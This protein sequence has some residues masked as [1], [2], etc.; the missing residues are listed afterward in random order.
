M[1]CRHLGVLNN[2]TVCSLSTWQRVLLISS[3]CILS[4]HFTRHTMS[5]SFFQLLPK[6]S[7]SHSSFWGEKKIVYSMTNSEFNSCD[8]TV[9]F[10]YQSQ[11]NEYTLCKHKVTRLTKSCRPGIRRWGGA[12]CFRVLQQAIQKLCVQMNDSHTHT[13][14]SFQV[15]ID[16][17]TYIQTKHISVRFTTYIVA[18][19]EQHVGVFRV[20]HN[21]HEGDE[22]QVLV[23]E[24][25][26]K[27]IRDKD[28]RP[29]T[30][31]NFPC[32]D[33]L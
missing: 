32:Q 1:R 3:L 16:R 30:S 29:M 12:L 17:L 14:W 15:H 27:V 23:G 8:A 13:H 22:G 25:L 10:F 9:F 4:Y 11:V 5:W 24:T 26:S 7:D 28:T 18:E 31:R 21:L 2:I 19:D 6:S 20:V 33:H